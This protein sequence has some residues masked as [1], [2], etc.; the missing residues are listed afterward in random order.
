MTLI[1]STNVTFKR[2]DFLVFEHVREITGSLLVFEVSGLKSLSW[3]LPNLRVIGGKSLVQ[4]YSLV[5]YRNK[6]LEDLGLNNLKV[7]RNGGV[8]I[9]DNKRLCFARS[10]DWKGMIMSH[11]ND[12]V[13]DDAADLSITET[14]TICP[15]GQCEVD[16]GQSKCQYKGDSSGSVQSCWNATYCHKLC[17]F[18]KIGNQIGPGCD[19][20]GKKCDDECLGG[21]DKAN[22]PRS[23]HACRNFHYQ[24]RCISKCADNLYAFL[25]RRCI[26][27]EK[28]LSMTPSGKNNRG[29]KAINGVCSQNCPEGYEEDPNNPNECLKCKAEC[30]VIC[31]GNVTVDD[32][33]KALKLKGCHIIDGSLTI[34]V[35]GDSNSG[36]AKEIAESFKKIHTIRGFLNIYRSATFVNLYMFKNL[37]T[38]QGNFLHKGKYSLLISENANL[39]K[40]FDPSVTFTVERGHIQFHN[41]RMLCFHLIRQFMEMLGRETEMQDVDQ[42][43]SSNG[44]KAICE[45]S[46]F[47]VKVVGVGNHYINLEWPAFNTTDID[48]RKFLGY[49]VYYKEVDRVDYNMSIDDNRS[50]C[51]DSWH[52]I[53][54]EV[55][56]DAEAA[57]AETVNATIS[58]EHIKPFTI[59]AF[60]VSTQMVHH[61]GARNAISKIGFTTTSFAVPEAPMVTVRR[62]T[63]DEI[64]LSWEPP[65]KPNGIITHYIVSWREID[66]EMHSA[67]KHF[68]NIDPQLNTKRPGVISNEDIDQ[69]VTSTTKAPS[70]TSFI[71][72]ESEKNT[73]SSIAGCCE[74]PKSINVEQTEEGAEFEN[75]LH[76]TIFVQSCD[77]DYSAERCVEWVPEKEEITED[78]TKRRRRDNRL[79]RVM[80]AWEKKRREIYKA[81]HTIRNTLND[82]EAYTAVLIK[83]RRRRSIESPKTDET[84]DDG[85]P[86]NRIIVGKKAE[87]ASEDSKMPLVNA[88]SEKL[89]ADRLMTRKVEARD[90]TNA[91]TIINLRHYHLYA[92]SVIAC[93]DP[94]VEGSHCS[95]AEKVAALK[96]RTNPLP[97]V[98]LVP[99]ESIQFDYMNTT[100]AV[101]VTWMAPNN[102]NGGIFGYY[103]KM[104]NTAGAAPH[105]ICHPSVLGNWT[106]HDD[107]IIFR[108][109]AD[110]SYKVEI[111]TVSELKVVAEGTI[112]DNVVK[113]YT[114]G[115]WTYDRISYAVG[116]F[117]IILLI[118]GAI[119][120]RVIKKH[121]GQKVKRLA[122]FMSSNPEY[123]I[124]QVYKED[125]WE[126]ARDNLEILE[127]IGSGSFG[128]VYRGMGKDVQSVSGVVFGE[129]AIKT[130]QDGT[131]NAQ[132]V[133]FLLEANVMKTFN[134]P[135]IVKL[136]GVVS[137]SQP[138]LCV[139][140]FMALGNLRDH[141]RSRRPDEP[142]TS[143]KYPEPSPEQYCEWAAQIAD[144]MAYLESIKFCHRDLAA[145]N[146]M[147][148]ADTT[149]K[150]GDFGMARDLYYTD[151]YKPTGKRLMP[152]RWMAPESLKDGKFDSKS[153]CWSYGIVL[154]EMLTLGQQPYQGLAND[155]VLNYIGMNKKI[156]ERPRECPSYWYRMMKMCWKY[157]PIERP[158]FAAIV[159]M[160]APL[161]S[162]TFRQKSF[163]LN[164]SNYK[165]EADARLAFDVEDS[166]SESRGRTN[167]FQMQEMF[168]MERCSSSQSVKK[169]SRK[170]SLNGNRS[171]DSRHY[172]FDRGSGYQAVQSSSVPDTDNDEGDYVEKEC[173]YDDDYIRGTFPHSISGL[174]ARNIENDETY[175]MSNRNGTMDIPSWGEGERLNQRNGGHAYTKTA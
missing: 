86:K 30:Q 84:D 71:G 60:Y 9:S 138:T 23:C 148:H 114:P 129:C 119:L 55:R 113:I 93:Q 134:A 59:Y 64:E 140:E 88:E 123:L 87:N 153:D 65:H 104:I 99:K 27:K 174:S 171:N 175:C 13:V 32:L 127:E 166:G 159:H 12:V 141:L 33:T 124:E 2:E 1:Y 61:I 50:A 20:A 136:Y 22:D 67:S 173:N 17:E 14:G 78:V 103:I 37:K 161:T 81:N 38:I 168:S 54:V 46:S 98:D 29:I 24:G 8:R 42:S 94:N 154:Y 121:Y 80:D 142:G 11:V 109:L 122:D 85:K 137:S 16:I 146:C 110:G 139:M 108:N 69:K 41:N 36:M 156:L 95:K 112:S 143:T 52:S 120:F 164:N 68:C 111:I 170:N 3:I 130:V 15:M 58:N 56:E 43:V 102:S 162:E 79:R 44:D 128:K 73:C 82:Y 28:C 131:D 132:R 35:R 135:F 49:E 4:H 6:D 149:V 100:S 77:F 126:L 48:H 105:Q 163:V 53:F 133:H 39:K 101:R 151:Y 7:I 147:V 150:I 5:I 63:T 145:R 160:L 83:L 76:D 106:P 21:C 90:G 91:F 118:I 34:E 40:L 74:C 25:D 72:K 57:K 62:V 115:F 165:D 47:E 155:E 107:G 75:N 45:D 26:T 116:L 70:I 66:L 125:E 51:F 167:S 169:D 18:D 158:T 10:I 92:I 96:V 157:K 152:V 97:D 172:S 31:P 144:G 89:I 117:L 19:P